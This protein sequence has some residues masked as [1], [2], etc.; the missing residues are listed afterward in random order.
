M[1]QDFFAAISIL[2]SVISGALAI[3]HRSRVLA[4][5]AVLENSGIPSTPAVSD[6]LAVLGTGLSQNKPSKTKCDLIIKY[7][8][9]TKIFKS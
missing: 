7:E 8:A 9:F 5:L 3:I 2:F 1:K 4:A 6:T